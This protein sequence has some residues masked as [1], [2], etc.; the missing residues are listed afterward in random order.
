MP[1]N[2]L[3]KTLEPLFLSWKDSGEVSSL[4]DHVT[5]LGNENVMSLLTA[6]SAP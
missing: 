4:G 2:E 5:K 6:N 3:E 1:L